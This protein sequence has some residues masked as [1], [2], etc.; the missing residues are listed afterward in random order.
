MDFFPYYFY[1]SKCSDQAARYA[2]E[3]KNKCRKRIQFSPNIAWA[4]IT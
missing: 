3:V 2:A 1:S 4:D